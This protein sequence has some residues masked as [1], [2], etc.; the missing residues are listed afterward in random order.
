MMLYTYR[1]CYITL[2][3]DSDYLL[4]SLKL[5]LEGF[6]DLFVNSYGYNYDQNKDFVEKFFHELESY[7]LGNRQNIASLVNEFFD[8]LLIRAL[9]VMLFV[10]TEADR[11]V[12][13]CVASKL[14]PLKP[15]DQAPEIIRSM[16]S[17]AFPPFRILRN[18]FL[19]GNHVVQSL[20]KTTVNHSCIN[21]WTKLRYCN[22]C[23]GVIQPVICQHSC[24]SRLSTCFILWTAFDNYWLS[25][26]DQVARVAER[27]KDSKS[28][29][30]VIRPLQIHISDAIMNLQTIFF[31]LEQSDEL[32]SDCLPDRSKDVQSF[33]SRLN[34]RQR[35]HQPFLFIDHHN[36]ISETDKHF[37]LYGNYDLLKSW[38]DS[39]R[40]KYLSLRQ[41]FSAIIE[42]FCSKELLRNSMENSDHLCWTGDKL[43]LSSNVTL[44]VI[45]NKSSIKMNPIVA[46][47]TKNL[48]QITEL[49]QSVIENNADP[50]FMPIIEENRINSSDNITILRPLPN[51]SITSPASELTTLRYL[52]REVLIPSKGKINSPSSRDHIK[53]PFQLN[54][55][56]VKTSIKKQ[57]EPDQ[58]IYFNPPHN[59]WLPSIHRPLFTYLHK[60]IW[61]FDTNNGNILNSNSSTLFSI[62][63]LCI[64][65]CIK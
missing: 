5:T 36:A 2:I 29:P 43:T 8:N 16:A 18:S 7:M 42:Y 10:K 40:N 39:I 37:Y 23:S 35:R 60:V 12:A 25:F 14:K 61:T 19:L 28:F 15:F 64:Y 21:E 11:V 9:H 26:I 6:H 58:V 47:V 63:S 50:N 49:L 54:E 1:V 48:Q 51:H 53:T 13:K 4:R 33:Y 32:F 17:R 38:V 65:L 55:N 57:T 41:P 59:L 46:H 52:E 44:K 24:F 30:Q 56:P 34:I 45:E 31:R 22:L 3:N 27:L 62:C 20:I